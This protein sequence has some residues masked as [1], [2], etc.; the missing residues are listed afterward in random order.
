MANPQPSGIELKH[1]PDDF[2][3][4]QHTINSILEAFERRWSETL[5]TAERM[6]YRTLDWGSDHPYLFALVIFLLAWYLYQR[7]K[8]KVELRSMHIDYENARQQA[9]QQELPLEGGDHE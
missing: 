9:R 7:R 8:T 2:N 5:S 3:V 6:W 1:G 4:S